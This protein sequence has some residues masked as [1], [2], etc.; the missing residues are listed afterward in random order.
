MH[1][2][3]F[4]SSLELGLPVVEPHLLETTRYLNTKELL[5]DNSYAYY[6]ICIVTAGEDIFTY[7]FISTII[8]DYYS[9]AYLMGEKAVGL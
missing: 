5:L 4:S 9:Y 8:E 7:S 6:S 2:D 1:G 3:Y